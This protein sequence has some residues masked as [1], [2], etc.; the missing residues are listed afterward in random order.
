MNSTSHDP[1]DCP[2]CP[3]LLDALRSAITH[4]EALH[5]LEN[6]DCAGCN[7]CNRV[8]P[9]FRA[10]VAKAEGTSVKLS[11]LYTDEEMGIY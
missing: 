4:L 9:S 2:D 8:L 7:T 1:A 6:R 10:L 3:E 5:D 11:D